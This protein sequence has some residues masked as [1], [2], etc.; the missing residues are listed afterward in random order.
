MHTYMSADPIIQS[1]F[2]SIHTLILLFGGERGLLACLLLLSL[3]SSAQEC[4]VL[5]LDDLRLR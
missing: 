3:S 2:H 4:G 5:L 1:F